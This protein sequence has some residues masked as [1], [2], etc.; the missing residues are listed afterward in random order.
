[1]NFKEKMKNKGQGVG[2]AMNHLTWSLELAYH[3]KAYQGAQWAHKHFTTYSKVVGIGMILGLI[4]CLYFGKW[5]SAAFVFLCMHLHA[6]MK[7]IY[8]NQKTMEHFLLEWKTEQK[9]QESSTQNTD[10][11]TT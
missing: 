4:A 9:P 5:I 10:S 11:Q 2:K 8:Y 3:T 1:M 6:Y 7:Q